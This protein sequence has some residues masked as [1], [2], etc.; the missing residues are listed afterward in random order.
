VFHLTLPVGRDLNEFLH[1]LLVTVVVRGCGMFFACHHGEIPLFPHL[2]HDLL[3][4]LFCM[5]GIHPEEELD[6]GVLE[7]LKGDLLLHSHIVELFLLRGL[8]L[9][10]VEL[11]Y[12]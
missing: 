2:A 11:H 10:L 6:S 12:V 8:L 3:G 5:R 9:L 7:A 1:T 4:D